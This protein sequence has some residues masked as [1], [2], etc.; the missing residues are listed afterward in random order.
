MRIDVRSLRQKAG[1][2][3]VQLAKAAG[4]GQS[5][6]AMWESKGIQPT[7]GNAVKLA[8]ALGLTVEQLYEDD[9]A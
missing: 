5:T 7:V 9:R 1:M 4:V 6:V 3:Q 2:T 8:R